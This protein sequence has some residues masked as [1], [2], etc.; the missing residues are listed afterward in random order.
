MVNSTCPPAPR[1]RRKPVRTCRLTQT[2]EPDL[3]VLTLTADGRET[4]YFLRSI[5]SDDASHGLRLEKLGAGL[6]VVEVY[7]VELFDHAGHHS[8]ECKGFLRWGHCRHVAGLVMLH[9]AGTL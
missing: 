5:G 4:N 6:D 7:H 2:N 8:C 9:E 1:Q 3:Q